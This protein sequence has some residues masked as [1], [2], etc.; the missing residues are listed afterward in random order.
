M[1]IRTIIEDLAPVGLNLES[2]W[3]AFDSGITEMSE[4][5]L[6]NYAAE[7]AATLIPNDPDF[8]LFAGRILT[9]YHHSNTHNRF[10]LT[11]NDLYN[12]KHD[13]RN[14]SLI[15]EKVYKFIKVNINKLENAIDYDKD[16]TY[17]VFAINTLKRAYLLKINGKPV[18]RIQD[19]LMR[20]SCGIHQ[21]DVD[22]AIETYKL[23]SEKWFTHAT[24]TL[25]NSGTP[26]PQLSSCFLL[27]MKEDSIEG[28]FDTLKD[29]AKISKYAG[30]I[31]LSIHDIRAKGSY[32]A[33][34]NGTSNGIVPM[35]KAFNETARYVDQGGGKR[36]GSFAI[37]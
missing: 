27:T 37:Y 36:K 24:P 32:I 6:W 29:C 16:Y 33:G 12:Y 14:A 20:V 15:D 28:I 35:L 5:N 31:G 1:K 4:E 17:D 23:L 13:G 7:T 25:F 18:E 26:N 9:K 21:T 8:G 22:A 2:F 10:A 11:I 19:M 3:T 34:T 30:G